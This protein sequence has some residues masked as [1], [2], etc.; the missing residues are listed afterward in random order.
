MLVKF[1]VSVLKMKGAS[2]ET[3]MVLAAVDAGLKKLHTLD[4][5][6]TLYEVIN[7]SL[8]RYAIKKKGLFGNF[9]QT[10]DPH[11]PLLGTPYP[12]KFLVFIL[13]FRT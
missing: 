4:D 8:I 2:E 6:I 7:D 5:S 12:T 10:S 13:H 11:P 3:K 9:S 1:F